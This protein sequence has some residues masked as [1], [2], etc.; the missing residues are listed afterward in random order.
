VND[1]QGLAPGAPRASTELALKP[2]ECQPMRP[3]P[4]LATDGLCGWPNRP[5]RG[6]RGG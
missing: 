3:R 2:V 6:S 5:G 1:V 4:A